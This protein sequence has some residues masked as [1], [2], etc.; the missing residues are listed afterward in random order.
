[1]GQ[2]ISPYA[3]GRVSGSIVIVLGWFD[4]SRG[5]G[6]SRKNVVNP[7]GSYSFLTKFGKMEAIEVVGIRIFDGAVDMGPEAVVE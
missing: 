2:V 5:C 7:F 3:L 4:L 1:M 6:C